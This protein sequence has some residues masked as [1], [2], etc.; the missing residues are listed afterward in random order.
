MLQRGFHSY[1]LSAIIGCLCFLGRLQCEAVDHSAILPIWHVLLTPTFDR[2]GD[3]AALKVQQTVANF[4]FDASSDIFSLFEAIANLALGHTTNDGLTFHDDHGEINVTSRLVT[5][6][7]GT[8]RIWTTTRTTAGNVTVSY[9]ALPR[10][11]QEDAPPGPALDFRRDGH[12]AIGSGYGIIAL[13]FMPK[14]PRIRTT[15]EWDLSSADPDVSAVSSRGP[16][17]KSSTTEGQFSM[18]ELQESFLLFGRLQKA[19]HEAPGP[20]F[21]IYWFTEPPFDIDHLSTV[22]KDLYVYMISFFQDSG[23][24]FRIFLRHNAHGSLTGTALPNSFVFG[25][26][27]TEMTYPLTQYQREEILAHEMSHNWVLL[28]G[29]QVSE[30]WYTEGLADY[31]SV[32]LRYRSN[33]LSAEQYLHEINQKMTAYYTNPLVNEDMANVAKLTW[34]CSHAQ[35]VPY[36]RGFAFGLLLNGLIKSSTSNKKNLDDVVVALSRM[37]RSGGRHNVTDFASLVNDLIGPRGH[38]AFRHIEEM[39]AGIILI[40]PSNALESELSVQ[41]VRHDVP[42]FELGFDEK[43]L[44][45]DPHLVTGLVK[46]SRAQEAGLL[47]GDIVAMPFTS[48]Y[49]QAKDNLWLHMVLHVTRTDDTASKHMVVEYWPRARRLVEAYHYEPTG[50]TDL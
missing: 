42:A 35:R 13:P 28:P 50:H 45:S 2:Y 20:A 33:L 29:A 47:N 7:A 32:L 27:D 30:N 19:I 5:S 38:N 23:Q 1:A 37:S 39:E 10:P 11:L 26:D 31:Y 15:L 21:N 36:G 22:L 43:S 34:N 12:G 40:P 17:N 9:T 16:G 4:T 25:W 6:A 44:L 24:D 14:E 49:N 46:G 3:P 18:E 8:Q 41:R 48:M